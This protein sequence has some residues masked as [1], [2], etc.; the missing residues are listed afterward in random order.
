MT[1]AQL[2]DADFDPFDENIDEIL[3]PSG[4]QH[5]PAP[6]QKDVEKACQGINS[7][8]LVVLHPFHQMNCGRLCSNYMCC[9]EDDF[10]PASCHEE[11]TCQKYV[12]CKE[13]ISKKDESPDDN[14]ESPDEDTLEVCS[15]DNISK[16]GGYTQCEEHCRDHMC[17]FSAFGCNN[18]SSH[19]CEKH[20][21]CRILATGII[22]DTD[23]HGKAVFN[24]GLACSKEVVYGKDN[25]RNVCSA[26][27]EKVR[28]NILIQV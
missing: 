25:Q 12:A 19:H 26:I 7:R 2:G 27:C 28:S 6:S 23:I 16:I 17:C 20:E 18:Y 8:S 21:T 15:I 4:G 14:D 10:D 11:T 9:F 3:P 1:S 22:T 13:L 24:Y 5:S